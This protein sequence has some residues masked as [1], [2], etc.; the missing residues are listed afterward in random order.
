MVSAEAQALCDLV[1]QVLLGVNPGYFPAWGALPGALICLPPP[2]AS[3]LW[4]QNWLQCFFPVPGHLAGAGDGECRL[5][6][7]TGQS[8]PLPSPTL[9][10]VFS[11]ALLVWGP[12]QIEQG[13]NLESQLP[14]TALTVFLARFRTQDPK[15]N[16]PSSAS[17]G[18]SSGPSCSGLS[19]GQARS[20]L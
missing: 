5:H 7:G 3:P 10:R 20:H 4:L 1:G 18:S 2:C 15:G 13:W 11:S 19:K 17:L 16:Q 9:L 12:P 8:S 6:V 14:S